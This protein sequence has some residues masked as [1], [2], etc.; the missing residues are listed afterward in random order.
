MCESLFFCGGSIFGLHVTQECCRYLALDHFVCG[1]ILAVAVHW[2]ECCENCA[3]DGERWEGARVQP[4]DKSSK[5][6]LFQQLFNLNKYIL[7]LG[8]IY[9][10]IRTNTQSGQ[11]CSHQQTSPHYKVFSTARCS[12]V[13]SC[14]R[15]IPS[16][17]IPSHPS[18]H[19]SRD[20]FEC[21]KPF[22]SDLK[23]TVTD[24][25]CLWLTLTDLNL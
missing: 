7:Q 6:K 11:G 13:P 10:I 24:C 3:Q 14:L 18:I 8:Q 17:P 15:Y 4:A 2:E 23:Q 19:P 12:S 20:S 1:S 22:Y 9:F 25:D 21:S 5:L 16:H